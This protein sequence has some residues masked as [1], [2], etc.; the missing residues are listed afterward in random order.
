MSIPASLSRLGLLIVFVAASGCKDKADTTPPETDATA[1]PEPAADPE[2]PAD[3]E[4]AAAD[5]AEVDAKADAK[6]DAKSDGQAKAA[7]DV[8]TV[9][10]AKAPAFNELVLLSDYGKGMHSQDGA[11]FTVLAP[12]DDA[13][14]KF[15]KAAVDRLK[16]KPAELD[17]FVRLHVI[18][19]TNDINKLTNF[20]TAPT[21][22]GKDLEVKA[23]DND[24]MVQG[25]KLIDADLKADNGVVHVV[26]R[27]IKKK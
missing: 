23:Q 7:G 3:A 10:A 12:N 15:G 17:E 13:M 18:L 1:N 19:G 16:K 22:A 11:G 4:P 20:R 21:A 2:P 27:V 26:D 6:A 24:V 14:G 8:L 9:L 5:E 25:V